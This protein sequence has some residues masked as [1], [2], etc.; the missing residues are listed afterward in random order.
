MPDNYYDINDNDDVSVNSTDSL[1]SFDSLDDPVIG[2][3]S[4][5]DDDDPV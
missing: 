2:D 3:D 4:G 1:G 5:N